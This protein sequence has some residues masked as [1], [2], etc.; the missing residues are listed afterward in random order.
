MCRFDNIDSMH[1]Q[2]LF[3]HAILWVEV[4]DV[5]AK[6]AAFSKP[7]MRPAVKS[8]LMKVNDW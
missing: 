4:L 2:L 1:A 8:G 5:A 6:A 7:R 3:V